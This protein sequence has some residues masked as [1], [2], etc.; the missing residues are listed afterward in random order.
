[1][2]GYV[3]TKKLVKSD[4]NLFALLGH[5]EEIDATTTNGMPEFEQRKRDAEYTVICNFRNKEDLDKFADLI[6]NNNL[7]A[8]GKRV[9]TVWYPDLEYGERGQNNLFAWMDEDDLNGDEE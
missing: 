1:M 3:S 2:A 7:K 8:P 9:K 5:E 4:N 6:G